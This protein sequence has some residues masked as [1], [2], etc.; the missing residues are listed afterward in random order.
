MDKISFVK[1]KNLKK[2]VREILFRILFSFDFREENIFDVAKEYI[3]LK[4]IPEEIKNNVVDI[5]NFYEENKEK[6]DEIIKSHLEKWRLE[7]L[8]FVER[9]ALRLGI[10]ELLIINSKNFN[11]EEKSRE[12]KRLILDILDIVDCYTNS[13]NSVRFVNGIIGKANRE[14]EKNENSIHI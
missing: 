3:N 14:I 1:E 11:S 13:K 2:R 4:K 12:I 7:R 9:A 5:L 8:G 6:I 10:A